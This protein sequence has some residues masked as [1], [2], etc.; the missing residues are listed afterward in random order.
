[1]GLA[2]K[3]AT[4]DF[5]EQVFGNW[6]TE[7]A[8]VIG[9]E[10]PV[11]VKWD[12]L[13]E[14]GMSHMYAEAWSK[15]YF[16]PLIAACKSICADDMG[17]DALKGALKKIEIVNENGIYSGESCCS[18]SNGTLKIDHQP[19]SNIDYGDARTAGIVKTLEQS[20]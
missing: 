10:V 5:Q 4:K 9:F 16:Q 8:A 1:M 14:E 7:L 11:E 15:V 6:K 2:E 3:R 12:Q 18:F 13:A 17:R 20:L 19:H